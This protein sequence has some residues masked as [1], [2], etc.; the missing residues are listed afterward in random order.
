MQTTFMLL[1]LNLVS[2]DMFRQLSYEASKE[3]DLAKHSPA[4]NALAG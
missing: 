3:Q 2:F 1:F 4:L